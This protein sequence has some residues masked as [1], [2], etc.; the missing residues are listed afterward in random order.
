M[1]R[2]GNALRITTLHQSLIGAADIPLN[3]FDYNYAIVGG[4]TGSCMQPRL[5]FDPSC[6]ARPRPP[7]SPDPA[8]AT[9]A[10]GL[11]G[12]GIVLIVFFCVMG[13]YFAVGIALKIRYLA[14]R[15][16]ILDR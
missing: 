12:G 1:Q 7:P 3:P 14:L 6:D 2:I 16:V 11:S 13:A 15:S 10:G 5:C 8:A 9:G 4:K